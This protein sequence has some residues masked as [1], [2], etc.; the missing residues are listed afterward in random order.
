MR[1]PPVSR[2]IA[3]NFETAPCE[4]SLDWGKENSRYPNRL[5]LM[6]RRQT[7]ISI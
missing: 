4:K 2:K 5:N 3:L 7:Q 1:F 6:G